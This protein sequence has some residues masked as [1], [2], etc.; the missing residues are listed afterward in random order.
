MPWKAMLGNETNRK[1]KERVEDTL[2]GISWEGRGPVAG[3]HALSFFL[4]QE[5]TLAVP[6]TFLLHWHAH[7]DIAWDERE[8]ERQ[9]GF[10]GKL[11]T[12]SLS[13][14]MSQN[15]PSG[16]MH[17]PWH[18]YVRDETPHKE[19]QAGLKNS[20]FCPRHIHM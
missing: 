8:D 15:V 9:A 13:S 19:R 4:W 6:A 11:P 2:W 1:K 5:L 20:W 14:R 3:R 12:S 18:R 10:K 7:E 16:F 17:T